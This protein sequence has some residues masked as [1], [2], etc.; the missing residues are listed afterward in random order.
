MPKNRAEIIEEMK[1]SLIRRVE[2]WVGSDIPDEYSEDHER[3]MAK[4]EEIIAIETVEDVTRYLVGEQLDEGE[5]FLS[6]GFDLM[7]AGMNPADIPTGV[8]IELGSK[9]ASQTWSGGSWVN[10]YQYGAKYFSIGEA[11]MRVFDSKDEAMIAAG[12]DNDTYDQ[13]IQSSRAAGRPAA[14]KRPESKGFSTETANAGSDTRPV[15]IV[16]TKW[17]WGTMAMKFGCALEASLMVARGA[18]RLVQMEPERMFRVETSVTEEA[19][20]RSMTQTDVFCHG[21]ILFIEGY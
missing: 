20:R 16:V 13:I 19:F 10:I 14:T 18:M 7:A 15:L 6:G 21:E 5:F 8:V 2:E 4:V 1:H 12:I 3:W 17:P 11:E 9:V